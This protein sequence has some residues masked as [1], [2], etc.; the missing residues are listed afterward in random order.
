MRPYGS[1]GTTPSSKKTPSSGR[2]KSKG[3][4]KTLVRAKVTAVK[5]GRRI[6]TAEDAKGEFDDLLEHTTTAANGTPNKTPRKPT[7]SGAEKAMGQLR[8]MKSIVG[9]NNS[10][11]KLENS[12]SVANT[13]RRGTR[14]RLK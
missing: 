13:P 11:A 2:R 7:K 5:K 14:K 8:K 10:H 1:N 4:K 12:P 9:R 3:V 6:V